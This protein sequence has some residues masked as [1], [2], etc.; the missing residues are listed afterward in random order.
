MRAPKQNKVQ[1]QQV[2]QTKTVPA[3][4]GGWN[5]RDPYANMS[6]TDALSMENLIPRPSNVELRKGQLSY[7]SA[8]ANAVTA[9]LT[10]RSP[11]TQEMFAC[12]AAGIYDASS[13]GAFG[14]VLKTLTNGKM[15][16]INFSTPG[17]SFLLAVNGSD[18]MKSYDGATWTDAAITGVGIAGF[19]TSMFN[20][21]SQF[22]HR[23]FLTA[24][25]S[26]S[27]FYMG[28]DSI[29][30][31]VTE[32]PLGALFSKGGSLL[33]CLNWTIDGG[34]GLDDYC[35]FITTEGEAA[36]YQGTDPSI[37]ANW[38]L[39][40]IFQLPRPVGKRCLTKFGGDVLIITESGI[41]PISK[42]LQSSSIDRRVAITDKINSSFSAATK[43]YSQNHG[44]EGQL[45]SK[46][47]LLL[48]NIPIA[49]GT[50]A[51]QYVMNTITGSWCKLTGFHANCFTVYN[52]N[53]YYGASTGVVQALTGAS[54]DGAYITGK[55]QQ[56]YNYFGS[57]GAMKHME[58]IRPVLEASGTF[59]LGMALS[60]S[61]AQPPDVAIAPVA[62]NAGAGV[63][64]TGVWDTATWGYDK[65]TESSWRTV[66]T[67]EGVALSLLMSF[68]SNTSTVAWDV[69]DFGFTVGALVG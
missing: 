59:S 48:F 46:E 20:N 66:A 8:L 38:A 16:S 30:G 44:W 64:D 51:Y 13:P 55:A 54:D 63:F 36:L 32:F 17:G 6:A 5:T 50:D 27:F 2:I 34:Q 65:T 21:I 15:E 10:Y 24:V 49:D 18:P 22:K 25:G 69:T 61:F 12:T 53:L 56:A 4:V 47:D 7:K 43:A 3:P 35:V 39:R 11:L 45:F 60:S 41:Y 23:V 29:A 33:A 68:T 58:L 31:A 9:L 1:G 37:A 14:A 42:A 19:T 28:L 67:K 40:G 52:N 26:S 62:G 57:R